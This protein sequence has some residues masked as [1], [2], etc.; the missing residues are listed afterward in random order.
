[1]LVSERRKMWHY[2][3]IK[4]MYCVCVCVHAT[5]PWLSRTPTLPADY[6]LPSKQAALF[7]SFPISPD[8]LFPSLNP[9]VLLSPP[10][11]QRSIL[12]PCLRHPL[13]HPSL[14]LGPTG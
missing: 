9:S 1:M 6:D 14:S 7:L 10:S 11:L 13:I 3:W 4:K 8:S 2:F 12:P 5:R